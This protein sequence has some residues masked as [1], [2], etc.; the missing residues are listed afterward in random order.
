MLIA[1]HRGSSGTAPENTMAAFREAVTA[2]AGMIELDVR[3]THD[4]EP[5]VIHDRLLHRT[6]NGRGAV[7]RFTA[8][9]LQHLDAGSW[10]APR[11]AG[12]RIP[13]LRSVLDELPA[14][15]GLDIEVKT[16]G[17][18]RS[19]AVLARRL[20]AVIHASTKRRSLLISSFDH[21]FLRV[22]HRHDRLLPLGVLLHPVR[23]VARRP[24]RLA[25]RLEAAFILCSRTTVRRA[26]VEQAHA[27]EVQVGVYTVN[28]ASELERLRR[29]GV[30]LVITNVPSVLTMA[31]RNAGGD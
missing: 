10:F 16:D 23:D 29:F 26:L 22:L 27:R 5:V 6:T 21:G 3:F 28:R 20:C 19:R 14:R 4:L 17:D 30:D 25:Q 2:G 1:A 15:T 9:A 12:E 8:E 24:S 18:R 7:Q 11:F 31:L 13:F